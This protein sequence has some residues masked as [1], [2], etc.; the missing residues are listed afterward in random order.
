MT[1]AQQRALAL[2][3]ARYQLRQLKVN[4]LEASAADAHAALD[5]YARRYPE[6]GGAQWYVT[7]TQDELAGFYRAWAKWQQEHRRM[8]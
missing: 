7:A 6:M 4:L 1:R 8:L 3:A 2:S 5:D